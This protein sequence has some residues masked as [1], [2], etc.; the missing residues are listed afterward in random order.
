MPKLVSP[1]HTIACFNG[2][3][4]LANKK[5]EEYIMKKQTK[6]FSIDLI[7]DGKK[8]KFTKKGVKVK[9]M[10]SIL[11][12]YRDMEEMTEAMA[13]GEK[14]DDLAVLDSM[15]VL[16]VEIFEMPEVTFEAIENS[17]ELEDISTILENILG[18]IM[19]VDESKE[20]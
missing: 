18:T 11:K 5:T 7:I 10:R 3:I 14:V 6:S 19:G 16:L 17:I 2:I 1:R 12:Y 4:A 8:R 20:A 13:R 9:T 15:I